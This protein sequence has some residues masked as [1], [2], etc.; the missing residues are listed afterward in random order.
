MTPC[1]CPNGANICPTRDIDKARRHVDWVVSIKN[2]YGFETTFA[3]DG[4]HDWQR[5][6][7]MLEGILDTF[8]R[9]H[10]CQPAE[11]GEGT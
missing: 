3:R 1:A 4:I 5:W 10:L 2:R 11:R 7:W 6:N 8:G 9:E